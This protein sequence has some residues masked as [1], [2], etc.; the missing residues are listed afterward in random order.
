MESTGIA[1]AEKVVRA[2]NAYA[3]LVQALEQIEGQAVCGMLATEWEVRGMLAYC[4]ELAT[5][6]LAKAKALEQPVG[7]VE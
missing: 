7:A 2:V 6:A 4:R 5:A 1:N 3:D